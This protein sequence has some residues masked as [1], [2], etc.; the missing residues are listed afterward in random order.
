MSLHSVSRSGHPMAATGSAAI[1]PPAADAAERSRERW[2]RVVL[3][4]LLVLVLGFTAT[5][6]ANFFY[7]CEPAAGSVIQPPLADC[8]VFL[9]P[10]I[11][12][13]A[14]GIAIAGIGYLRVG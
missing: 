3:L 4:G 11:G 9:S 8:A 5:L 14:V 2:F 7:P 13:I 12:L 1:A 10:W 6:M